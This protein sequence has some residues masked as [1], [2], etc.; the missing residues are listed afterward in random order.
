MLNNVEALDRYFE[1]SKKWVAHIEDSRGCSLSDS[2]SSSAAITRG[3]SSAQSPPPSGTHHR[4]ATNAIEQ[5]GL[6]YKTW[7]RDRYAALVVDIVKASAV[8]PPPH[9][10]SDTSSLGGVG[11]TSS[12]PHS[13]DGPLSPSP[14]PHSTQLPPPGQLLERW[15][16]QCVTE[17]PSEYIT[18]P[19]VLDRRLSVLTR[20]L[21]SV[22][23]LMPLFNCGKR[24]RLNLLSYVYVETTPP[25]NSTYKSIPS[26]HREFYALPRIPLAWGALSIVVEFMSNHALIVRKRVYNCTICHNYLEHY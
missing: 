2:S 1:F 21:Y 19:A 18:I 8:R 6:V 10:G 15:T 26:G 14:S 22:T 4:G 9:S 16:I 25:P 23:R 5:R 13:P 7:S 12:A 17:H 20:T 11:G 24:N 3:G